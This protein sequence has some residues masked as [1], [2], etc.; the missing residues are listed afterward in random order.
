MCSS[1]LF[2]SHDT[3]SFDRNLSK[4]IVVLYNR[5]HE[6]V[7]DMA[8]FIRDVSGEFSLLREQL[9]KFDKLYESVQSI[10]KCGV[11][12]ELKGKINK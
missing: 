1:D 10:M 6:L 9:R 5:A 2:P 4:E 3:S 11:I 7:R 8:P 12:R